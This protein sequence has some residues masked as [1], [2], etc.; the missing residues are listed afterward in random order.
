MKTPQFSRREVLTFLLGDGRD[1]EAGTEDELW[2]KAWRAFMPMADELRDDGLFVEFQRCAQ[3]YGFGPT[4]NRG[5]TW[6]MQNVNLQT[7]TL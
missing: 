1:I 7:V 3:G 5:H 6:T 2:W 4:Q